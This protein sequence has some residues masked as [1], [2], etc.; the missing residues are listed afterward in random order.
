M[1]YLPECQET[2]GQNVL[3]LAVLGDVID[4]SLYFDQALPISGE[5]SNKLFDTRK[6]VESALCLFRAIGGSALV[7]SA[8][9]IN[10]Y[11][12][13]IAHTMLGNAP[14][15]TWLM[16]GLG[17]FVLIFSWPGRSR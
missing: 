5:C 9:I 14:L 10:V 12:Q 2:I 17:G 4:Q 8:S 6:V 16:G 3:R 1:E 11:S 7:P 13:P 15:L